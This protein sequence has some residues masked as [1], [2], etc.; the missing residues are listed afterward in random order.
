MPDNEMNERD[1]HPPLTWGGFCPYCG[2]AVS[3]PPDPLGEF[4]KN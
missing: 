4:E 2:Q 1:V 3:E